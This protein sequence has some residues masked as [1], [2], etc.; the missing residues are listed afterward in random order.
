MIKH[1]M[2][3][4]DFQEVEE[5]KER[6]DIVLY[7]VFSGEED[8]YRYD[9][10]LS[11]KYFID[12]DDAKRLAEGWMKSHQESDK[13]KGRSRELRSSILTIVVGEDL[14]FYDGEVIAEEI[15][16]PTGWTFFKH[17]V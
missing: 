16:D 14:N 1:Q 3:D 10:A 13:R 11:G 7:Y 6:A 17:D 12:H 2:N 15:L 5:I 4:K 8:F 9:S